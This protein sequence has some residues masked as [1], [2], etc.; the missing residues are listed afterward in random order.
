MIT[1]RTNGTTLLLTAALIGTTASASVTTSNGIVNTQSASK[2]D[3]LPQNAETTARQVKVWVFFTNKEIR[4]AEAYHQ[5][6]ARVAAT[7][8]PRPRPG[9]DLRLTGQVRV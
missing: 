1:L 4:S 8:N 2:I 5:A 3:R 6:I 9:R 7:Y